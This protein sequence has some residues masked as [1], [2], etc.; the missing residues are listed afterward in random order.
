MFSDDKVTEIF[1]MANDFCNFFDARM[2]KY[3]LPKTTKE[4]YH[5]V[6]TPSKAEVMVIIIQ[7][8][9]LGCGNECW[10]RK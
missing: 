2:E 5:R 9:S 3:S 4:N 6:G 7:F 10:E 8:H 1:C